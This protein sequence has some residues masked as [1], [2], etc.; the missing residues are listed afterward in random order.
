MPRRISRRS[1]DLP[2]FNT[3]PLGPNYMTPEEAAPL[4]R[5]SARTLANWRSKGIGP[6]YKKM[7]GKV[8]YSR[9]SVMS[10]G[11]E[12]GLGQQGKP[13]VTI[14]IRPA[15]RDSSRHQVDIQLQHPATSE[16]VRRRLTAPKGSTPESARYW[17]E[18]QVKLILRSL[19]HAPYI[20]EETKAK[21]PTTKTARST[22]P[23]MGDLWTIYETT[24]LADGEKTRPRTRTS[25]E[26]LWRRVRALVQNIPCDAWSKD[27][28]KAL[29]KL[30][31]G[32]GARHSNQAATIINNLF[33]VAIEEDHIEDAPNLIRRKTKTKKLVP[34][35]NQDDLSQLLAAAREI[36]QE[37]GE[38]LELMLLLSLDA[39][40]RPGEVAGLRWADVDWANGQLMIQNQRPQKMPE[41][42]DYPVKYDEVGRI[43]MTTRLRVALEIHRAQT[44]SKSRF[45]LVSK[46]TGEAMYSDTISD[47]VARIHERSGLPLTKRAHFLRHCAAS[48][49]AHHPKAGVADAQDLLRH[50]HMSTTDIYLRGIRGSNT[51][52]RTA[53]I[54][55]LLD[56]EE[57]GTALAPA[58]TGPKTDARDLH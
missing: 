24:I 26:K 51:S 16:V 34:A 48:R 17:G 8:V 12:I 21:T 45:V 49:L 32:A 58:G 35:H 40:L 28:S 19:F 23:T 11:L 29:A 9:A 15:P 2:T 30:F 3:E 47:R 55:D 54:F 44:T 38:A 18:G 13:R 6:G 50:K 4:L 27:N 7:G 41:H 56:G 14:T 33:R 22:A 52:R 57:T 1:G 37:N 10:F 5:I 20:E 36:S 31:K 53:A 42:E 25:Y 39:G 46:K 43:T